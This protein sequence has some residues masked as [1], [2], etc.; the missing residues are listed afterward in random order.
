MKNAIKYMYRRKDATYEDIEKAKEEL[1][2][3]NSKLSKIMKES[4]TTYE[5]ACN[6]F[7]KLSFNPESGKILVN[8]KDSLSWIEPYK[9]DVPARVKCVYCDCVNNKDYGTCDFCGA[10]LKI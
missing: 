9:P 6:A 10:P 8:N 2:F 7:G 5:E 1:I 3:I 4:S